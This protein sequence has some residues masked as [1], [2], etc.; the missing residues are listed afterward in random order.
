M[1]LTDMTAK[2]LLVEFN[3]EADNLL[4]AF[5]SLASDCQAELDQG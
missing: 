5:E 2:E 3:L 1:G 4:A